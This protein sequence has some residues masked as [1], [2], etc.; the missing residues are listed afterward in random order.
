M[1]GIYGVINKK[2][3]RELAV[4][5]LDTLTHRGPDGSGLWQEGGVTLGHRRLSILDLSDTGS[6]PMPYADGESTILS[7][8]AGSFRKKDTPSAATAIRR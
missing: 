1:C 8:S 4:R 7:R 2:T 3:D 6:Q 5:C